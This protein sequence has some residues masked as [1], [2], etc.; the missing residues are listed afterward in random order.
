MIKH[1]IMLLES[2]T[3]V[4]TTYKIKARVKFSGQEVCV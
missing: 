3:F 1:K 4:K 2:E